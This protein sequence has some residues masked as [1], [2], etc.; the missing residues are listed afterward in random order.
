MGDK[1]DGSVPYNGIGRVDGEGGVGVYLLF[2]G[3]G[4][5]VYG[6]VSHFFELLLLLLLLEIDLAH[7][8]S[9]MYLIDLFSRLYGS[10]WLFS[11]SQYAWI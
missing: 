1:W 8:A 6:L 4:R 2:G 3:G 7:D 5:S 10:I 11:Y 9:K